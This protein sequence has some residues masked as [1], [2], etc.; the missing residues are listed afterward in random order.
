MIWFDEFVGYPPCDI[1]MRSLKAKFKSIFVNRTREMVSFELGKEIEKGVFLLVPSSWQYVKHL[2]LNPFLLI[3]S[4]FPILYSF[5]QTIISISYF[6]FSSILSFVGLSACPGEN[7]DR[8][9]CFDCR[10]GNSWEEC[11]SR[12]GEQRCQN[13]QNRCGLLS[14]GS[15]VQKIYM[16][17]CFKD[18]DCINYQHPNWCSKNAAADTQCFS[19]IICCEHDF[20]N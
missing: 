9:S 20:C 10:S 14:L 5:T 12:E 15:S 4:L 2:Y 16:K 8:L 17:G 11:G 7:Q 1:F 19:E 18:S 13:G 6:H 3:I